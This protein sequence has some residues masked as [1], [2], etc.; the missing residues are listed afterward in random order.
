[1]CHHNTFILYDSIQDADQRR[2]D[3]VTHASILT[4]FV[5]SA[6]FGIAGYATFT[7]NSQGDLLEN[8]CWNDDLMNVSRIGFSIT[9]LLTF[10]I[11]CFV[12]REVIE[13]SFF[14]NQ[15]PPESNWRKFRHIGITIFIVVT[16]YLIS[17]ATD[18]LGLVLELNGVL[19]AVPLAYVLPAVSYLKL[20]EGPLF[21]HKKFPALCL[22]IFG[23]IIAV[24]GIV[25]LITN[26]N[27]VDTC[28]HGNEPPYCFVN[29]TFH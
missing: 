27:K 7:G 6:L 3:T 16:T 21:S 17:M 2:W 8:Y 1:M 10:P 14:S 5:V 13:N 24:L 22:A 12:S 28:S 20:E 18:C 19:A 11:E 25:L 4:S 9:I 29:I 23:I 15:L 26:S